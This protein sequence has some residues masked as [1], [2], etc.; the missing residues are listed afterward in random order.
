MKTVHQCSYCYQVFDTDKEC[1]EH[2]LGC[3]GRKMKLANFRRAD[4]CLFCKHR[5]ERGESAFAAFT[6]GF[7]T[8]FKKFTEN[9]NVCNKFESRQDGMNQ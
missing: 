7:C 9:S 2:E 1:E 4:M 3:V 6:P 5:V 8:H